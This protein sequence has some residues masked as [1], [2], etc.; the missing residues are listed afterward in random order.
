MTDLTIVV[1]SIRPD[2][3][4]RVAAELAR[5][6][7]RYS[8]ELIFVGP[9][10]CKEVGDW[11]FIQDF[12]SPTRCIQIGS[13]VAK[14]RHFMWISD[15]GTYHDNAIESA[16]DLL[17]YD[18]KPVSGFSQ[19]DKIVCLRYTENNLVRHPDYW[20][21]GHH[22][23][24]KLPGVDANTH[25]APLAL[26]RTNVFRELGGLDCSFYHCNMSC[27]DLSLRAVDF[28]RHVVLS[29]EY[30][31]DFKWIPGNSIN[32]GDHAVIHKVDIEHDM[33]L[34]KQIYAEPTRRYIDYNNWLYQAPVWERFR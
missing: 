20:I 19:F 3:W 34:F 31:G 26:M 11:K 22:D 7:G 32:A 24:L 2:N 9:A 12:G 16:L 18:T 10:T 21:T 29:K 17:L 8:H 30:V 4:P 33:P 27:I 25:F 15:D 1:P 28:G 6:V 13:V 5:S 14:G 23:D